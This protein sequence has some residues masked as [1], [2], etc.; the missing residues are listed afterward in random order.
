VFALGCVLYEMLTGTIPFQAISA[1]QLR[2]AHAARAAGAGPSRRQSS[3]ELSVALES[4]LDRAWALKPEDRFASVAEMWRAVASTQQGSGP[5]VV[6]PAPAAAP[7]LPG[8]ATPASSPVIAVY[9][10]PISSPVVAVAEPAPAAPMAVVSF[11]R[12]AA[13]TE[14]AQAP[15]VRRQTPPGATLTGI[16]PLPRATPTVKIES[17]V[18]TARRQ[19][20]TAAARANTPVDLPSA[21]VAR[22]RTPVELPSTAAARAK[23][24]VDLPSAPVARAKTPVELPLPEVTHEGAMTPVDRSELPPVVGGR[25][26]QPLDLAEIP[27]VAGGR[28]SP[29]GELALTPTPEP[30]AV[31]GGLDRPAGRGPTPTAQVAVSGVLD[32]EAGEEAVRSGRPA[33]RFKTRTFDP[34]DL[35]LR[36]PV[37][38]EPPVPPASTPAAPPPASAPSSLG[39]ALVPVALAASP[40][41]VVPSSVPSRAGA[42]TLVGLPAVIAGALATERRL[43]VLAPAVA[44]RQPPGQ[45]GR[46][47]PRR[48]ADDRPQAAASPAA[49]SARRP[50]VRSGGGARRGRP[51]DLAPHRPAAA[52]LAEDLL[53]GPS[54]LLAPAASRRSRAGR[55]RHSHLKCCAP[56]RKPS[57]KPARQGTTTGATGRAIEVVYK[58]EQRAAADT[59]MDADSGRSSHDADRDLT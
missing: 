59:T 56:R 21:P 53:L 17:F 26:E 44:R 10:T 50:A 42:R 19:T 35:I 54:I 24:P 25:V 39:A 30:T 31:L 49:P 6:N 38:E 28:A 29:P 2:Q 18:Q 27:P 41:A 11:P 5:V 1:Q 48:R 9:P 13:S 12:P 7:V 23:T 22:A 32:L 16:G 51:P 40:P 4:V 57:D 33:S 20:P 14:I 55:A 58:Y 37:M 43:L 45:R 52:G 47:P 3:L 8:H 15:A 36:D 46:L 34:S